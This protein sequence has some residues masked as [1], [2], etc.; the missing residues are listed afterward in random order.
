MAQP[1]GLPTRAFFHLKVLGL[2]ILRAVQNLRHPVPGYEPSSERPLMGSREEFISALY[3]DDRPEERDY[4]LGKIHNLRQAIR[5]FNG[6][7]IPAGAVLS[8][9]RQLGPATRARGFVSGRMLQLAASFLPLA[10]AC[11]NFR[12]PSTNSPFAPVATSWSVIRTLTASLGALSATLPLL[13]TISTFAFARAP[14]CG[15]ICNSPLP[16]S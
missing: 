15:S 12:T 1:Q 2:T 13:S 10:A 5:A 3:A 6:V 4:E 7:T 14:R 9:W 8:F 11:V 16:A